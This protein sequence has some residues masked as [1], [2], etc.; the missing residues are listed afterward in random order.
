MALKD[1][2]EMT[3]KVYTVKLYDNE[4]RFRE[5]SYDE[6]I[7]AREMGT[8]RAQ[9][10]IQK[11]TDD[12]KDEQGTL[13]VYFEM[14]RSAGEDVTLEEFFSMPSSYHNELVLAINSHLNGVV[15]TEGKRLSDELRAK[16]VEEGKKKLNK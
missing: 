4:I 11:P 6:E 1:L 14:I 16:I 2:I 8:D 7:S 13:F 10:M 12:E 15:H 3:K 9:S 5:L